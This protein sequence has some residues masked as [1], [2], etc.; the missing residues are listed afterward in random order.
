MNGRNIRGWGG[1]DR[2]NSVVCEWDP[3]RAG[4]GCANDLPAGALVIPFKHSGDF[5][6]DYVAVIRTGE[7]Y[8][9]LQAPKDLCGYAMKVVDH[10]EH[11]TPEKWRRVNSDT[12]T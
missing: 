2:V 12:E 10:L 6:Y 1:E 5:F 4:C 3:T 11:A 8:V 7:G 9:T